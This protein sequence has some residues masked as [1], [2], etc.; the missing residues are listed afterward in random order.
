MF[1]F[2]FLIATQ[3]FFINLFKNKQ[4]ETFKYSGLKNS[5]IL[6][7]L[8]ASSFFLGT[9]IIL[10]FYNTSSNL[11]NIYLELKN[12]YTSDDKYL[13]VITNNGLWIKDSV[14]E[15][16]NIINASKIDNRYLIGASIT[17][18]DKNFSVIRHILSEK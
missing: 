16:I 18:L 14:D 9:L 7:I 12:N 10:L 17:E 1:P 4:I 11:K 8:I 2:I 5:K 13:A 6:S 15:K 3:L